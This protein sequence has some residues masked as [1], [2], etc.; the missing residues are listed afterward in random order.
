MNKHLLSDSAKFCYYHA[1]TARYSGRNTLARL[2]V[3]GYGGP[4]I[5]S[6][7]IAYLT[8]YLRGQSIRSFSFDWEQGSIVGTAK[9]EHDS[10][11]VLRQLQY[12]SP[13]LLSQ[14]DQSPEGFACKCVPLQ[15]TS[16]SCFEINIRAGYR[17][18]V[19]FKSTLAAEFTSL[20][21]LKSQ[22]D[23]S[24]RSP[25]SHFIV[26]S[27]SS[28]ENAFSLR[29]QRSSISP[30]PQQSLC[31]P[32]QGFRLCGREVRTSPPRA[33]LLHLSPA[34]PRHDLELLPSI[35][36]FRPLDAHPK[37]DIADQIRPSAKSPTPSSS[38]SV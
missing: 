22:E 16:R 14:K 15:E 28:S 30:R 10:S 18:D 19:A 17:C 1:S 11:P 25:F 24:I 31:Y 26:R 38:K 3:W 32:L 5:D 21:V 9:K 33:F 4:F 29:N 12:L 8:S 37:R 35:H 13:C 2:G 27:N 23:I 7:H 36:I 34:V 20:P 6:R